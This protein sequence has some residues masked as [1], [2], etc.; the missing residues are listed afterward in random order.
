[1]NNAY[2]LER[3]IEAQHKTYE[4]A[5]AEI[6]RGRKQT[7]WM[8]FI[9]PQMDGLG[10]SET[11]K[12]YAIKNIDEAKQFVEHPVLGERLLRICHV[13]LGSQ[14]NNATMIFG[15]PDDLKLQSSMTLFDALNFDPVFQ[16]VL[17]KFYNGEKDQK[18][19][20]IIKRSAEL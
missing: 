20:K 11:S 19:L 7:H 17:D 1:M 2:N 5:L 8:W 14:S 12:F 18:T 4:T 16:M 13:L 15:R 9:F 3:F 10:F 6:K